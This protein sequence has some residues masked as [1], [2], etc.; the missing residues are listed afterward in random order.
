MTKRS[1][2]FGILIALFVVVTAAFSYWVSS[3]PTSETISGDGAVYSTLAENIIKTG[4]Y[5]WEGQ[6][7]FEREP[8]MPVFLAGV[9]SI[10]GL[11]NG[12]AAFLIQALLYLAAVVVFCRVTRPSIGDSATYITAAVLL[13]SPL[14]FKVTFSLYRESLALSLFL[15]VTSALITW[16]R[17][18]K[19]QFAALSGALLGCAILVYAPLLLLPIF[20]LPFFFFLKLKWQHIALFLC[21]VAIA[22]APWVV[23]NIQLQ[24]SPCFTG[25]YRNVLQWY[26]RAEQ[27]EQLFGLEPLRCLHAEYISRDWS[28]RS[29]YCSFNA[30]WHMKW[31][32]GF[33]GVPADA[34][35]TKVS[36]QKIL[37]NFPNYLWISLFEII[38][39]HIPFV[40]A[41]GGTTLNLAISLGMLIT[42]IGCACWL[43]FLVL[44]RRRPSVLETL[45]ILIMAYSIALFAL[46]DATPRYLV[47]LFFCYAVL[48]GIGFDQLF[49]VIRKRHHPGIQ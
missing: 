4:G 2:I 44:H 26:V 49:H 47:P 48:S 3:L 20:L 9:Y 12:M 19:I 10:F 8:G 45:L 40:G 11:Q 30:V 28:E 35:V 38:E 42:Y 5:T 13:L 18:R 24:G 22:C 15:F 14:I 16:I 25:C 6:P 34:E 37:A 23:R 33:V 29:P 39:F 46:T 43:L 7:F 36:Q 31:P 32:E 1:V 17:T 27:S 41:F 21:A